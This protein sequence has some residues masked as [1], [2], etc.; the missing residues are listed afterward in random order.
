MKDVLG[1]AGKNE[2]N[3]YNYQHSLIFFLFLF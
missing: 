3:E 1:E 2:F